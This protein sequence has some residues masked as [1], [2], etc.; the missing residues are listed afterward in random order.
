[1][2]AE[3]RYIVFSADEI[4]SAIEKYGPS[5]AGFPSGPI[6]SVETIGEEDPSA[7]VLV[8]ER[9]SQF[10]QVNIPSPELLSFMIRVCRDARV[11][12]PARAPKQLCL[13]QGRLALA[14]RIDARKY[15]PNPAP[16]P[17][18]STVAR[19]RINMTA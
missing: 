7:T 3:I 15:R 6:V 11:P 16:P 10:T 8:R 18:T 12:L 2:P 5:S 4:T 19:A 13:L 1:V 17:R 14:I 9:S